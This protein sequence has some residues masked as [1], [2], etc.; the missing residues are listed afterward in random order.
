MQLLSSRNNRFDGRHAVGNLNC[1]AL[2]DAIITK[3]C[4]SIVRFMKESLNNITKL[5]IFTHYS[6][7]T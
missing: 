2:F 5:S 6:T 7:F 1:G 3:Q 4:L